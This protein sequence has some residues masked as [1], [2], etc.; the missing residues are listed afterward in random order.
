MTDPRDAAAAR[1]EFTLVLAAFAAFG[2]MFGAWQVLLVEVKLAL[3]LPDAALGAAIA[4]GFVG[5][6][7]AMFVGGRLVD[8]FGAAAMIIGAGLIA[9]CAFAL[10]GAVGGLTELMVLL[11]CFL[12]IAGAYDVGIN[13]AGMHVERRRQRR[14]MPYLHAGYSGGA[15]LGAAFTGV[16]LQTGLPFR[17]IFVLAALVPVVVA[18]LVFARRGLFA[19]AVVHLEN[20]AAAPPRGPRPLHSPTV[21]LIALITGLCFFGEG[22]VE[23]WSALY[24]RESFG[25]AALLGAAGPAAF[26]CAMFVG[27]MLS[28]AIVARFGAHATLRGAGLAAAAGMALALASDSI[29]LTLCGFLL[30]GLALAAIAPQAFSIAGDHAAGRGGEASSMITMVGYSGFL[31]GPALIGGLSEWH[32]LKL[33]LTTLIFA[34]VTMSA[35]ALLLPPAPPARAARRPAGGTGSS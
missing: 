14:A 35:L 31:L 26:H 13:A 3:G 32:G 8:R 5:S 16:L 18:L 21:W 22:S 27:R 11:F 2:V 20:E 6:Y 33:A 25:V 28:A 7:P 19:G 34:G 10:L 24:L 4:L 15:A 17:L 29:G 30:T 23:T 1:L 9:A 12:A